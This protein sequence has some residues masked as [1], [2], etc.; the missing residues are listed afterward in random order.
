[1]N[2]RSKRKVVFSGELV[3]LPT[4]GAERT[5]GEVRANLRS[6]LATGEPAFCL[7]CGATNKV[8]ARGLTHM[9][10]RVLKLLH[11]EEHGLTSATITKRTGQTGGGDTSKLVYWD[12]IEPCSDNVWRITRKGRQ[13]LRGE[14]TLPHKALVYID[15]F[16]GHDTSIMVSVH[17][18]AGKAFDLGEVMAAEPVAASVVEVANAS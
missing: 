15:R 5:V 18:V 14:I 7:C 16:I 2:I 9:M 6:D 3:P 12:L 13:F 1:M 17:D 11:H 8:Y 4:A 10:V